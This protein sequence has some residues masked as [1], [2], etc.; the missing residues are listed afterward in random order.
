MNFKAIKF[1]ANLLGYNKK[2]MINIEHQF[3]QKNNIAFQNSI[4][5]FK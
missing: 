1:L 2:S 3:L 5:M 4:Q